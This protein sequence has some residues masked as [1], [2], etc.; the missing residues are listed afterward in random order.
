MKSWLKIE[1]LLAYFACL[2]LLLSCSSD[3][4]KPEYTDTPISG[5]IL[6]VVD[7]SYQ[8]LVQV[9]LDTFM[10]IYKYANIR[11]KYLPE[12][13]VFN[14]LMKNDSVR[15]AIVARPLNKNEA[16]FFDGRK[17]V[18][19]VNKLAVDAVALVT[20]NQNPD[21]LL[22]YDQVEKIFS[23]KTRTWKE[24]NP[25][26]GLDSIQVV[27][28]NNGS[29][30]SRYLKDKFQ[31]SDPLPGNWSA[32]N[33]NKD[34]VDY[35]SQNPRALGVV[36]VNWISDKDDP[37]VNSFLSK[38]KVAEISSADSTAAHEYYKP[39]Q[40]YIALKQYPFTRDVLIVI[41]EGRNGLGTGFASFAVG[42]Q[43][44]R[45]VRLMGMLPATMPIRIIKVNS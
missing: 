35:V 25:K 21:T 31:L 26:S 11:V 16:A 45:L 27:F 28:D 37:E 30:N 15:L 32:T 20:N 36:S 17:I 10:K 8:P 29:S 40:A 19:R 7:E 13:E 41:R 22:T 24:I 1:H 18:P 42:D 3:S 23:G 14:E 4:K 38:I 9:E 33:S 12:A 2:V 34:V 44:Q 6:I 39:Y 5:D 43:G